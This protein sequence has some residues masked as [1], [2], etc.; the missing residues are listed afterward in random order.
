MAEEKDIE[1]ARR[2]LDRAGVKV[3]AAEL[4]GLA[5]LMAPLRPSA[6]PGL[7]S[8]PQ[9]VQLPGEWEKR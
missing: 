9:L 1:A 5:A 4:D 6:V 7:A 8:E 2:A 3:T